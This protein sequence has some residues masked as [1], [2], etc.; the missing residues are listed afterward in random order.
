VIDA[1]DVLGKNWWLVDVQ[2]HGKTELQPGP[3][4]TPNSATGE[5]GQLLAMYIPGSVTGHGGG[6]GNDE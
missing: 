2:A 3:S 1:R 5:D 6:H 4:L